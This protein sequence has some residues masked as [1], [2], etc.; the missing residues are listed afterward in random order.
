[1]KTIKGA[2]R[3][4]HHNPRIAAVVTSQSKGKENAMAVAWHCP[5]SFDPPLYG[6]SIS[7]RRFSYKLILEGKE[8]GVNFLPWE[9]VELIARVGASKGDEINKFEA[10]HIEKEKPLMTSVP[11]I[12]DA[13]AVYECRLIDHKT[14]GDHEWFVGEVLATHFKPELFT[15]KEVLDI[16][17][18]SPILYLGGDFYATTSKES[19]KYLDRR[20]Y[21]I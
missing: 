3:F 8:F 4:N 17:R 9:K 6:V 20:L 16:S 21:K 2:G 7:P 5:I 19:L 14:Y 13:Y 1:M 12:K 15:E 18:I 10:F 11:I